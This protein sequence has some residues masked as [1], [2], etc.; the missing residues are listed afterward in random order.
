MDLD[1]LDSPLREQVR[2]Y[3]DHNPKSATTVARVLE[4]RSVAAQAERERLDKM[5]TFMITPSRKVGLIFGGLIAFFV[6]AVLGFTVWKQRQHDANVVSGQPVVAKVVRLDPGSCAIGQ[7]GNTCLKLGL[8]LHPEGRAVYAASVTHDLPLQWA[9]RVQPGSWITV[10]V[11][12]TDPSNVYFDES[13]MAV[14]A[15]Q[16][17]P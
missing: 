17:V 9:S 16:P 10:A 4:K 14:A 15:P 7:K 12:R 6:A 13:S 5:L 1:Q 2:T 8:E 11:D 3:L